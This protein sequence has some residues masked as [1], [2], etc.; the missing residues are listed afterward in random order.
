MKTYYETDFFESLSDAIAIEQQSF[1]NYLYL[2]YKKNKALSLPE[3]SGWYECGYIWINESR[4]CR[5]LLEFRL[6]DGFYL[7][8]I[9]VEVGRT[10]EYLEILSDK[11]YSK[12]AA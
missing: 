12:Q 11:L 4:A 10:V 7:G 5:S 9:K 8:T 6:G 3:E 2:N 1:S